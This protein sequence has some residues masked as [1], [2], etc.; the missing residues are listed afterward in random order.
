MIYKCKSILLLNMVNLFK[1]TLGFPLCSSHSYPQI[2]WITPKTVGVNRLKPTS[3]RQK[4]TVLCQF[5]DSARYVL[6]IR[7]GA[8]CKV[9]SIILVAQKISCRGFILIKSSW[10]WFNLMNKNEYFWNSSWVFAGGICCFLNDITSLR[11]FQT[12]IST[13]NVD[14]LEFWGLLC[15]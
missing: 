15:W 2:L 9:I 4:Y 6:C 8:V 3:Q 13:E 14:I 10:R 7:L 12:E 1:V 11:E 5:V